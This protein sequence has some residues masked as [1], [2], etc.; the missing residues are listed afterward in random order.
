[1]THFTTSFGWIFVANCLKE[2]K[3]RRSQ[4]NVVK[5]LLS[6]R[7]GAPAL[8]R[9]VEY[10]IE[11]S[12]FGDSELL[13]SCKPETAI[14]NWAIIVRK[15]KQFV[16]FKITANSS[17]LMDNKQSYFGEESNFWFSNSCL[18]KILFLFGQKTVIFWKTILLKVITLIKVVR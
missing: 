2:M 16:S 14:N 7:N 11:L 15:V 17:Y 18:D 5:K 3:N 9:L 1:M 8:K 10:V 12:N 4:P 13:T 6:R